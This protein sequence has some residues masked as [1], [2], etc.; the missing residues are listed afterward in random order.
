LIKDIAAYFRGLD[1]GKGLFLQE[2]LELEAE[3]LKE[4]GSGSDEQ[5]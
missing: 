1:D 5:Q 4:L 2:I 3:K